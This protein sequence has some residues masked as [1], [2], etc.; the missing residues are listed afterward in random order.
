MSPGRL[1]TTA[2]TGGSNNKEPM[3]SGATRKLT[4]ASDQNYSRSNRTV[5]VRVISAH[6]VR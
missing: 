3:H 2:H 1:M 5:S 4:A 6:I